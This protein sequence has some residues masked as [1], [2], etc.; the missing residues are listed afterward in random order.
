MSGNENGDLFA[1][2]KKGLNS[3]IRISMGRKNDIAGKTC[4]SIR[5]CDAE[6]F[7]VFEKNGYSITECKQCC[8]RFLPIE[9]VKSHVT[10]IYSDDY[11]F[12][13]KQGYP[14]YLEQKDILS[15]YGT[16]YAKIVAKHTNPG[17]MLD[18]GSA[19]GFILKGFDQAGW[20]CY[21]VEPNNTMAEYGRKKLGLNIMTGSLEDYPTDKKF[22]LVSM[23]QVIGH[24]YDLDKAMLNISSLLN[25]DGLVLIESWN[26]KSLIAGILGKGWHEYSPPSVVHWFSDKTLTQLF[27]YYGFELIEKGYPAKKINTN[28]ALSFFEDRLPVSAFKRKVFNFLKSTVG[29]INLP[30]PPV[31]V[32]WYL[33]KKIK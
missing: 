15:K 9:D 30:Y 21:G 13:G 2:F 32:K 28:H 24:F 31:D 10:E 27:N 17:K 29:K 8:H 33:F 22:D 12:E 25:K 18:V 26:M 16:R 11:F 1:A 19:A 14:N 5:T 3:Q 20:E 23:I 6:K 7:I 4:S